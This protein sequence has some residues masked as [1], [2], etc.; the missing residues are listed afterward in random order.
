MLRAYAKYLQQIG[1]PLSQAYIEQTLAAHPRIARMLVDLFR[2]RFD[3][4]KRDDDGG[5]ARR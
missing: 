5:R 1:F 2:L 3:P 4:D